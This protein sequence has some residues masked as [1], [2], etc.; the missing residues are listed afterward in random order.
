MPKILSFLGEYSI[1]ISDSISYILLRINSFALQLHLGV[2]KGI[3]KNTLRMN[4]NT[5]TSASFFSGA[6]FA[7]KAGELWWQNWLSFSLQERVHLVWK[8]YDW[9]DKWNDQLTM[10]GDGQK[11]RV[12]GLRSNLWYAVKITPNF[13]GVPGAYTLPKHVIRWLSKFVVIYIVYHGVEVL[14]SSILRLENYVVWC[15]VI[16]VLVPF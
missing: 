15:Q 14:K 3:K 1:N 6:A 11:L 7:H 16:F 13:D 9:R 2:V 10:L 12:S 4:K 8:R 5:R